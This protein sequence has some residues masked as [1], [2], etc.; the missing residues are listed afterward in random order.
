M[1]AEAFRSVEDIQALILLAKKTPKQQLMATY[2]AR[3]TQ[4]FAVSE[5]HLYHAYAWLKMFN[6]SKSCNKNLT[7]GDVHGMASS[8]LLATLS[9]LPYEQRAL[10]GG[11][12][13]S[14]SEQE[15]E[16]IVRMANILG[17]AVDSKRDYRTLL[18]RAALLTSV[19]SPAI[20]SQVLPEVRAIYDL[21]TQDFA[22]LELCARLGPLV[23]K[24]GEVAPAMSTA[25]PVKDANLGMYVNS[26]K[27]VALLR[28]LKQLSEVYST[29]RVSSLAELVSF[30][31]LGEVEAVVMDAVKN[32]YLQ[33]R[34]DHRNGTLHF[35]SQ[36]VE[37]DHVRNH[38]SAL[39]HRL[40][41]AVHMM[42]P[43]DS[44]EHAE[45]RATAIKTALETMDR[46]HTMNSGRKIMIEKRKEESELA[47]LEAEKEE[48][49]RRVAAAREA[50][51]G[52]QWEWQRDGWAGGSGSCNTAVFRCCMLLVQV[53]AA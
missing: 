18:S 15:K 7:Q 50:E 24:L 47:M 53:V 32:D 31:P 46:E 1:W 48:E 26:L 29:M 38:L 44:A 10:L 20:L 3:L 25:S 45:A 16:R 43:V 8:V 40:S 22:P 5:N 36:Q 41:K 13:D 2:Y 37:S 14:A 9:I 42:R 28:L 39:T 30:M 11:S 51:V 35:G 17:F 52:G 33:V 27:Q 12:D 34:I 4:I 21:L 49:R 19:A 23:E 6:F